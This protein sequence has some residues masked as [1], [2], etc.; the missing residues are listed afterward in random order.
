[1]ANQYLYDLTD[2]W[3]G[4]G[5]FDAIKMNVTDGGSN[6]ASKLLNLQVGA[7][8]KFTVQKDGAVALT[9][10]VTGATSITGSGTFTADRLTVTKTTAN[11]PAISSTG[12]SLTGSDASSLVDLA[13]TWNT[14]GAP[15]A[16][17]L[18]VTESSTPNTASLLMDLQR[19]AASQ[20][21]VRRDGAAIFGTDVFLLRDAANILAQRNGTTTQAHRVY[22]TWTDASNYEA[23]ELAH[24]TYS[25]AQYSILRTITAGSGADNINLVLSPSGNG[26]IMVQLP[27]GQ[28]AGGGN[29]RGTYAVD[30]QQQRTGKTQ[31]ASGTNSVI[32]GGYRNTAS[33]S[34]AIAGGDASVASGYAAVALGRGCTASSDSATAFGYATTAE[35]GHTLALGYRSK[36]YRNG[37]V[38][39]AS[40][41]FAAL[42]DAQRSSLVMS[43]LTTND[44]PTEL[45]LLSTGSTDRLV[46][47]NNTMWH[48]DIRIAARQV[49]G[50]NHAIY[51][52]KCCIY[53]NANAAST[54]LQGTVQTIGTDEESDANWN[55]A[56]TADT[57]NGSLKIEVT[58]V[59]ATNIRWVADIQLVEVAY[60]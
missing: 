35:A 25:S 21:A 57:T 4:G 7:S 16:I 18:N 14:S 5:T 9:G 24:A 39:Q 59:A 20:F 12:Y 13:G 58:G 31:V 48:A 15:T 60:A 47:P 43:N 45:S 44:T 36:A 46:L 38:A 40:S 28:D 55:V 26:A 27:D 1:M 34:Y 2:S 19:G 3:S 53:R 17:K 42:G 10:A 30:L 51:H 32:V 54:A 50:A 33:N 41:Y 22:R 49:G 8:P 6:A 11:A 52:R 23:L 56:I 37:Q 29:A